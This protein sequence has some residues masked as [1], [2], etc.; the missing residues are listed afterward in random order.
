MKKTNKKVKSETQEIILQGIKFP[1]DFQANQFVMVDCNNKIYRI[2]LPVS[3]EVFILDTIN[4]VQRKLQQ[5]QLKKKIIIPGNL[6]SKQKIIY[7][8]V[9]YKV[10]KR[11]KK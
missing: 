5:E 6:Q 2:I 8:P 3:F 1:D 9:N 10:K 7:V 11:G 4:Y